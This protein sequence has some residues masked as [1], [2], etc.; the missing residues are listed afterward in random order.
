M[1]RS[2]RGVSTSLC[3]TEDEPFPSTIASFCVL[4]RA[5]QLHVLLLQP[6]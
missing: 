1:N 2:T 3:S 4:H 6:T 5:P